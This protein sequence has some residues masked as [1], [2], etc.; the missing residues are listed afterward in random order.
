MDLAFSS[1]RKFR[2]LKIY[3][4][5]FNLI[6]GFRILYMKKEQWVKYQIGERRL[7]ILVLMVGG[8]LNVAIAFALVQHDHQSLLSKIC[9]HYS[10]RN[11]EVMREYQ[12]VSIGHRG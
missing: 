11:L 5:L 9:S 7:L 4:A 12:V 8:I 10:E 6:S 3:L 2:S 1:G